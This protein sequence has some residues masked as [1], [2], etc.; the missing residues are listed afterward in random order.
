LARAVPQA[1]TEDPVRR[2]NLPVRFSG[3][4]VTAVDR[5]PRQSV[6][7]FTVNTRLGITLH[8]PLERNLSKRQ[9][10]LVEA[11]SQ[12]IESEG[13]RISVGPRQPST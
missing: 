11:L 1:K 6:R 12:L 4:A 3:L 9:W 8:T 7:G 10:R 5:L 2:T 13:V